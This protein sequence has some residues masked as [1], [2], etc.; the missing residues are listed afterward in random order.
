MNL[1]AGL[2][3]LMRT[4]AQ[5]N[6]SVSQVRG[7]GDSAGGWVRVEVAGDGSISNMFLDDQIRTMP[8]YELARA[9]REAHRV[10]IA[11]ANQHIQGIQSQLTESS[12]VATML[13]QLGSV[14]SRTPQPQASRAPDAA[15]NSR[16]AVGGMTEQELDASQDAFNFDPLGRRR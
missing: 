9:I 8:A 16:R 11:D 12:Y 13:N 14:E 1:D 6:R 2:D 10:A 15:L 3:D 7:Q 4:A 5:V